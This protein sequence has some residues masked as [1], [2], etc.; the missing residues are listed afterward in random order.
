MDVDECESNPCQNGATCEDGINAYFC[1]CPDPEP[2]KLPWGGTDCG[3]QLTGCLEHQCQHDATCTPHL[4]HDQ[5][6]YTCT[7]SSGFAGDRC[8]TPTTFSFSMES[9]VLV[10]VPE[11]TRNRRDITVDSGSP[12]VRLRFRTTLPD[13]V[14]FYRGSAEHFVCLELV[15]GALTARAESGA[16]KMEVSL[17]DPVNDGHWHDALVTVDEKLTLIRED[18]ADDNDDY[19]GDQMPKRAEDSGQNQLLFFHPEGLQQVFVGGVPLALHNNTVSMR[20]FL[21]CMEDLLVDSQPILPQNLL[22]DLGLDVEIGCNKTDWCQ[23]DPCS[24]QGHCV[25]LWM[26]YRCDC[27][28]PFYGNVCSEGM[29][30]GPTT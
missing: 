21:G 22:S 19:G 7:C 5:H 25:D 24:L 29:S 17:L 28:R 12:S 15:R 18:S 23:E 16:L 9:F 6:A 30:S 11:V 2:G 13:L 26:D 27:Q 10:E 8:D 1:T 14:L 20:G 4:E 3:T